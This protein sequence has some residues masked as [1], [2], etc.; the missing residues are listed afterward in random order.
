MIFSRAG[1]AWAAVPNSIATAIIARNLRIS[2]PLF[3]HDGGFC[4]KNANLY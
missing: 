2:T 3:R 1:C 4:F